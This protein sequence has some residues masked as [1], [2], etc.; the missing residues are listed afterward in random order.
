MASCRLCAEFE[1]SGDSESAAPVEEGGGWLAGRGGDE[2][3]DDAQ[4]CSGDSWEGRFGSC[5][6]GGRV[7][8]DEVM[9]V[10]EDEGEG[11]CWQI[12]GEGELEE[13][14]EDGVVGSGE[15]RRDGKEQQRLVTEEM[16]DRLFWERCLATGF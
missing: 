3:D 15:R 14:E 9:E 2:D 7:V 5:F 8:E 13:E 1:A 6:C 11:W 16:E 4:S 12:G 10:V